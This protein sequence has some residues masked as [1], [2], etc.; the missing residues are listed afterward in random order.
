MTTYAT[1]YDIAI[2]EPAT[3][4]PPRPAAGGIPLPYNYAI[5]P[6]TMKIS[7]IDAGDYF[8]GDALPGLDVVL[9]NN[10]K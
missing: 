5:D 4:L 3:V 10:K 1:P 2:G 8:H 9:A 6:R 7:A